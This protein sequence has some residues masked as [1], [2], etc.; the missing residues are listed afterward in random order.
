MVGDGEAR[1]EMLRRLAQQQVGRQVRAV[2]KLTGPSLADAYA[3]MDWF[4]FSSQ[5][6]TQGLVIAEAMAAGKPVC[7]LD[8]SGVREIVHDGENGFLLESNASVD[9][10]SYALS[11]LIHDPAM[12]RN[13]AENARITAES[14]GTDRCVRCMMDC[15][16]DAIAGSVST[17]TGSDSM[18]WDR[19]ISGIEIEWNLFLE[20]VSAAAAGM[21]VTPATEVRLD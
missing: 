21:I 5:T 9:A 8:G 3:A 14:Y 20:K 6:E 19:L 12:S 13:F 17:A 7:A 4:V 16:T 18:P 15:Y 2:G 11:S 1:E 10:F